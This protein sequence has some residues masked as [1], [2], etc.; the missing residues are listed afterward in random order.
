LKDKPDVKFRVPP[1]MK[2]VR[3][4]RATGLRVG[5]GEDAIIE[6]FKPGTGPPDT[7][8]NPSTVGRTGGA[9]GAITSGTG[10]LY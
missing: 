7:F 4:N 1:Q 10:G 6:A 8:V 3:V 9:A 2:L 5:P